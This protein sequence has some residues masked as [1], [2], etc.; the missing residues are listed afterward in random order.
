MSTPSNLTEHT[1]KTFR[2][3]LAIYRKDFN[4]ILNNPVP[5]LLTLGGLFVFWLVVTLL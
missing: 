1:K 5:L 3:T 4:G 2:D